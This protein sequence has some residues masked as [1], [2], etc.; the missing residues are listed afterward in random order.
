MTL[1]SSKHSI[2]SMQFAATVLI[3]FQY[4]N[5]YANYALKRSFLVY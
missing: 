2:Y 5:I 1:L 4:R 3:V